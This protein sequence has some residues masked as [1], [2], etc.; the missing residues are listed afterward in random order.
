MKDQCKASIETT[1][2]FSVLSPDE[3][4]TDSMG[5]DSSPDGA[6]ERS[7]QIDYTNSNHRT[8]SYKKTNKIPQK[9]KF[10]VTVMLGDSIIKDVKGWKLSDKKNKVVVKHFSGAKTKDMESYIIP[11]LEQNP[12]TIII[13]SGTNDLK[14][15]SSPEE[16]ARDIINLTTSCK[17]Q[18]NKV[19]L[20]SIVPRYDNLNEKATRVNKCLKKECEARNICFIDHRNISPKHNCNRSGL[21]LNHR[22]R[23]NLIENI[24][25]CLCK[26]D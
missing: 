23:K 21:H 5:K 24:L 2:R 18:T 11:T 3:N 14:S 10:P 20:S 12:E 7:I 25:F 17:T 6:C 19:I 16:I 26:S 13:H 8:P 9:N 4:P 1:N 15:D 22:R